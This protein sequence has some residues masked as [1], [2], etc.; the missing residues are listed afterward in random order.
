[1]D[2]AIDSSFYTKAK[3]LI[4][5]LDQNQQLQQLATQN[6][7][8][9][10][11]SAH[12]N[13]ATKN[14]IA[15]SVIALMLAKQSNDPRYGDLIK[16]GMDHRRTKMDIINDYKDQANQIITRARNNDFIK[17]ATTLSDFTEAFIQY[18]DYDE[19]YMEDGEMKPS[20]GS[21]IGA[22]IGA[23]IGFILLLPIAII[24]ALAG[25]LE[26]GITN[27]VRLF[28]SHNLEKVKQEMEKL[29]P[30]EREKFFVYN[31]T[32]TS[33]FS[34]TTH[35][36]V[37]STV[38]TGAGLVDLMRKAIDKVRSPEFNISDF[39]D[40]SYFEK[41]GRI[42]N[43]NNSSLGMLMCVLS[44][45]TEKFFKIDMASRYEDLEEIL[46][47]L[48]SHDQDAAVRVKELMEGNSNKM[49]TRATA[50]SALNVALGASQ[51]LFTTRSAFC[52]RSIG[53][54]KQLQKDLSNGR[55]V[56][57]FNLFGYDDMIRRI[58]GMI[59]LRAEIPKIKK[60]CDALKTMLKEYKVKEKKILGE[61]K[62]EIKKQNMPKDVMK[63]F[64]YMKFTCKSTNTSYALL[65]TR[66]KMAF[67]S[68]I[69]SSEIILTSMIR[70][71][72]SNAKN[73]QELSPEL[74]Q[75]ISGTYQSYSESGQLNAP[76][77]MTDED[78][79][80]ILNGGDTER[81]WDS[82]EEF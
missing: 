10:K 30:E 60:S 65:M 77:K 28:R 54:V 58:D 45:I 9:V 22:I 36:I 43:D 40:T 33:T 74:M 8:D 64:K 4:D 72:I 55:N 29:T 14:N 69:K 78:L 25:A 42:G 35:A 44:S 49:E 67:P 82:A 50:A 46:G 52:S 68:I 66:L 37:D 7:L 17:D 61:I 81:D 27:L 71:G 24:T 39:V 32:D 57:G 20:V 26:M 62:N 19:Y 53:K 21:K 12:L 79:N 5:K 13:E 18:D 63:A 80:G 16:Y 59:K 38:L 56:G 1:M 15:T 41:L 48:K 34:Q 76:T 6:G 11:N 75:Q 31:R 70:A 51:W 3:E 73:P 47:V 23:L 2:Y